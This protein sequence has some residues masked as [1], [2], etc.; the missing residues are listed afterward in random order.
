MPFRFMLTGNIC[1]FRFSFRY[2]CRS[3]A[4]HI[5]AS[6]FRAQRHVDYNRLRD[7][8]SPLA[9]GV[10]LFMA[11]ML[12]FMGRNS[13]CGCLRANMGGCF[14]GYRGVSRLVDICPRFSGLAFMRCNCTTSFCSIFMYCLSLYLICVLLNFFRQAY[15][16][17]VWVI[18]Q[19]VDGWNIHISPILYH[20]TPDIRFWQSF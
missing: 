18:I 4:R 2:R 16:V 3:A 12:R 10:C 13:I 17:A 11:Y 20:Y 1:A 5:W 15:L 19:V 6:S 7:Y 8:F 9:A 14:K